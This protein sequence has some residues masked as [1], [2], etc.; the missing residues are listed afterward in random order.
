MSPAGA[1]DLG[2]RIA[3]LVRS[4]QLGKLLKT[5]D[6]IDRC[7]PCTIIKKNVRRHPRLM[8]SFFAMSVGVALK[9]LSAG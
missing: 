2:V 8:I 5:L 9:Q 4:Q 3:K 1:R 6:Q 7:H